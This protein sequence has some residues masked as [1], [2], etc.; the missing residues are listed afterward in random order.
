LRAGL[1][2]KDA[3]YIAAQFTALR[4]PRC[5]PK[6]QLTPF[7]TIPSLT[8][9]AGWDASNGTMLLAVGPAM[10]QA[11]NA[12]WGHLHPPAPSAW[13]AWH[14]PAALIS[15]TI[16]SGD[17]YLGARDSSAGFAGVAPFTGHSKG[18]AA[19]TMFEAKSWASIVKRA[20]RH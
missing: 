4:I 2:D 9:F 1:Y 19:L 8:G 11:I 12:V 17:G 16:N 20:W 18:L 7:A 14:S 3:L 6:R 13:T 5:F 10:R 15:P